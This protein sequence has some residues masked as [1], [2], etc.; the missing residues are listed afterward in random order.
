M[1]INFI[2]KNLNNPSEIWK[3]E[4]ENKISDEE[5]FLIYTLFTFQGN[6]DKYILRNAFEDRYNY[7][8]RNNNFTRI[9]NAF[10]KSLELLSKG[11]IRVIR[12]MNE[13][14]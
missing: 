12:G 7:E 10:D 8:I 1:Y 13:K 14:I 5:R 3:N 11:F 6:I 9:Q 4:F 2:F